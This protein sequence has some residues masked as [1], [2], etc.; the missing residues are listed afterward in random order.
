MIFGK[1]ESDIFII[2]LI[3]ISIKHEIVVFGGKSFVTFLHHSLEE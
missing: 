1:K 2:V 3:E